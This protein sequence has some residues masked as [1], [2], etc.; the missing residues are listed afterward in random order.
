MVGAGW[1]MNNRGE[2]IFGI[3]TIK[4]M[5]KAVDFNKNMIYTPVYDDVY[6]RAECTACHEMTHAFTSALLAQR[7]DRA[8]YR[9]QIYW[10]T[11]YSERHVADKW[12]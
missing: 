1:A 12:G 10:G 9:R 3:K 11:N 4:E 7:R 5:K 8:I 6:I 2:R